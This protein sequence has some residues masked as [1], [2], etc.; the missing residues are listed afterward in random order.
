MKRMKKIPE[1]VLLAAA[2]LGTVIVLSGIAGKKPSPEESYA[3]GAREEASAHEEERVR[4]EHGHEGEEGGSGRGHGGHGHGHEA[5]IS[6]LDRSVEEMW[7]ARC[8]HDILQHACDECRFEIGTVRLAADLFAGNGSP[9]LIRVAKAESRSLPAS[10]TFTG[11][12]KLSEGRTVRVTSPLHGAVRRVHADIGAR[13]GPG[14]PLLEVDAHEAAEARGD[15][16]KKAVAREL[17]KRAAERE[18][19][20]FER[21]IAAEAEVLEAQ[22]RLAEAEVDLSGARARLLRLGVGAEEIASLS[23]R[24]PDRVTG[25]LTVRA[26]RAGTVLER[27]V[28][29]GELVEPG[30]EIILLSDLSEV[31]VWADV[32]EDDVPAVA[33]G[34]AG[35]G[36]RIP[37]EVQGPGG[38]V[39]RG[40]LDVL[41]GTMDERTRTLK[42]R[43]VVPN[44]DGLLRPG[45]FV[46][47]RLLLPG[48]GGGLTVPGA[49][50][51]SD[52]GRS[53]VFVH[54]EGDYWIRRPVTPGRILG[55]AVEILGGIE[56]GRK[57]VAD[58]SFLLKSDVLRRKMGAGCAD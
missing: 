41:S 14:D 17:A 38:K 18:A 55:D 23:H 46:T 10:R 1:L 48:D 54:K 30:K 37:A 5:E 2:V 47:V 34:T 36:G 50:V 19:R 21:K 26:P 32:R 25:L 33:A 6:D 11:E 27:R 57:V 24:S 42:A 8:E 43:I 45:M 28:N 7:A 51:I 35:G 53:F 56:P 15:Y 9:G 12:V 31:W 40:T 44:P 22:A 20:L 4:D 49:A 52:E 3:P 13:V 58:G 39:Y 29:P 16:V